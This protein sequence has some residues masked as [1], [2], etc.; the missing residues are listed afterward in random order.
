MSQAVSFTIHSHTHTQ[1]TYVSFAFACQRFANGNIHERWTEKTNI[2]LSVR[3]SNKSVQ[4]FFPNRKKNFPAQHWIRGNTWCQCIPI[5]KEQSVPGR[6][7]LVIGSRILLCYHFSFLHLY[8][9][10]LLLRLAL[11]V[12]LFHAER[13]KVSRVR[14]AA[15]R[16]YQLV[17]HSL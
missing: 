1:S 13:N 10:S 17:S 2:K 6:E 4:T 15:K 9:L 16:V 5:P 3:G 14:V 11:V 12:G 8:P 7:T